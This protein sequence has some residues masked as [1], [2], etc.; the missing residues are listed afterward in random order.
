MTRWRGGT[1]ALRG[2]RKDALLLRARI[3]FFVDTLLNHI[4]TDVISTL[5]HKLLDKLRQ[6]GD[7]HAAVAAHSAFLADAA[8]GAFIRVSAQ[9]QPAPRGRRS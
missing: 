2:H 8:K 4:Q 5:E 1:A 7:F 3:A 9:P 6:C